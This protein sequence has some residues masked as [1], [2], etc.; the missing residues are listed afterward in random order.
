[1][2]IFQGQGE[3]IIIL[4]EIGK[5]RLWYLRIPQAVF[6]FCLSL[7]HRDSYEKKESI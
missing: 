3:K 7:E 4:Y 6:L 2:I 1:M 5:R